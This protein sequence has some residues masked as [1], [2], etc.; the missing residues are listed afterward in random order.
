MPKRHLSTENHVELLD[1]RREDW[2]ERA[3][4]RFSI[5]HANQR[6]DFLLS[7]TTRPRKLRSEG[8][9]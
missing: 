6:R 5:V 2:Y 8:Y 3:R 4:S 9:E 1:F 7:F